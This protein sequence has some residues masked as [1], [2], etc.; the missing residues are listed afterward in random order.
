MMKNRTGYIYIHTSPSGLS[1]IGIS[2]KKKG[3]R[4]NEHIATTYNENVVEY[5][6]PLQRAIRKYGE[7]MFNTEILENDVDK[8]LLYELEVLYIE[9]E[10]PIGNFK[11]IF[12]ITRGVGKEI[13]RGMFKR[14]TV[15]NIGELYE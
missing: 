13:K 14:Y 11:N 7:D 3:T 8:R 4:W 10:W 5:N 6:Y 9:K 12:S 2:I 15:G 1:Y